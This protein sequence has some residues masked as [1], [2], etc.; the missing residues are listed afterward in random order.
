MADLTKARILSG[1]CGRLRFEATPMQRNAVRAMAAWGQPHENIAELLEI[2]PATLR[3]H[4]SDELLSGAI[5]AHRTIT[6]KLFDQALSGD[7][8][9]MICWLKRRAGWKENNVV[10]PL[11]ER[12]PNLPNW[13]VKALRKPEKCRNASTTESEPKGVDKEQETHSE[14]PGRP[15][16]RGHGRPRFHATRSQRM[17]VR[18]MA[19]RDAGHEYIARTI[20]ISQPTLR[21]YF[22]K[23]LCIGTIEAQ[24]TIA[25]KLY[26]KSVQGNVPAMIFWLKC[27]AGWNK[28]AMVQ[29]TGKRKTSLPLWLRKGF[30]AD[31]KAQTS[32]GSDQKVKVF[33]VPET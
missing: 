13:L 28:N 30:K 22:G 20:G 21:A 15:K 17:R 1:S 4:F 8:G 11:Y 32:D 31:E 12:K 25:L 3:Q 27:R 14:K 6:M 24:T 2:R 33:K 9:A 19:A 18:A 5:E 23:E 10:H 29:D 26:Q 16:S 7:V